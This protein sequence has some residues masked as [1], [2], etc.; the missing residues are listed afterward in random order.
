MVGLEQKVQGVH[1]DGGRGVGE[2][3]TVWV[4]IERRAWL[5]EERA[6]ETNGLSSCD[7][8]K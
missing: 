3:L 4:F 1:F 8:I 7:V 5:S 2:V 6:H